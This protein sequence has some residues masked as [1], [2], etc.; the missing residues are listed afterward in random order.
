M[1]R[2]LR[3][4]NRTLTLGLR[5][6]P[7]KLSNFSVQACCD[8]DWASDLDDM[9]STSRAEICLGPNLVF[10]WSKKQKV[11]ARSSTEAGYRS[12]ALASTEVTWIQTL[13]FELKVRHTTPVIFCDNMSTVSQAHNPV[14]HSR[15]KHMELDL[16]FVKEKFMEKSLQ[17]I[18][19]PTVDQYANILTKSLS[20]SNFIVFRDKLIVVHKTFVNE[21]PHELVRDIRVG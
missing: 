1:K 18:H 12:L 6:Q 15:T 14:L 13:L 2:I 10:W 8:A 5:L 17:V 3:Y 11:F 19:V 4:L 21:G 7:S 20:P 9:L 16:F